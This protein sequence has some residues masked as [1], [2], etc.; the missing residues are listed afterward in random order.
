MLGHKFKEK[1]EKT[2]IIVNKYII[3]TINAKI[4]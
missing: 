1:M 4:E 3:L 2:N